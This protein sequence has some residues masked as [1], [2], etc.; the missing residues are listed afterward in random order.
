MAGLHV[1]DYAVL[2]F[3]LVLVVG[4]GLYFRRFIHGGREFFVAGN[5]M[6][7]WVAGL[8]VFMGQFTAW[9]FTGAAGMV[10]QHG[11]TIMV[12]MMTALGGYLFAAFV[13]A[14][15]WRR[16]RVLTPVQ[17]LRQRY[18]PATIKTYAWFLCVLTFVSSAI[19][20]AAL[21]VFSSAYIHLYANAAL[22]VDLLILISG[23]IVLIYTLTG[24]VWAA[25][26]NDVVQFIILLIATV[27]VVPLS[28]AKVGGLGGLIAHLPA[29][30]LSPVEPG[31]LFDPHAFKS[32]V[33]I[34]GWTIMLASAANSEKAAQRYFSVP[35]E[36]HA[37]NSALVAGVSFF[38]GPI[39]FFI[40]PLVAS[41]TH[42][43]LEK[44]DTA[45]AV[46]ARD[47]LPVGMVGMMLAAMAAATMSTLDSAVNMIAGILS[48]DI[49]QPMLKKEGD[50]AHLLAIGKIIT[51]ILGI[52]MVVVA[53][54]VNH[55]FKT[56]FD[57]LTKLWGWGGLSYAVPVIVGLLSRRTSQWAALIVLLVGT[58]T[59]FFCTQAL[60]FLPYG[61]TVPI[62]LAV[63]LAMFFITGFRRLSRIVVPLGV[64]GALGLFTWGVYASLA[65]IAVPKAGNSWLSRVA[66]A[67]Y[68]S[69]HAH[70]AYYAI[71]IGLL[72]V[73]ATVAVVL[74]LRRHR[75]SI[76][77]ES[78]VNALFRE[79]ARPVNVA[80]EVERFAPAQQGPSSLGLTGVCMLLIAGMLAIVAALVNVPGDRPVLAAAAGVI[81]AVGLILWWRAARTTNRTER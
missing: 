62:V 70:R 44:V 24:G 50:D 59:A 49:F 74:L 51:I 17:F 34:V 9:T 5:L 36:R 15:R 2:V 32:L 40:P 75:G 1:I 27:F 3:Y 45:Y 23:F 7:W 42:P 30:H 71:G 67:V 80:E 43:G 72:A 26:F 13:M 53:V 28:L 52:G 81:G 37:R 63:S 31:R 55:G 16:S 19:S 46:V 12:C 77:Y 11:T 58:A 21:S 66:A 56:L 14:P 48:R 69:L 65:R 8:S 22:N 57:A 38:L 79:L 33:H 35:D 61:Y 20:L 4:I 39:L 25:S 41:I 54:L 47:V 60:A 29:G 73:T 18:N 76:S 6:P 68:S 78:D 64:A 10:Y